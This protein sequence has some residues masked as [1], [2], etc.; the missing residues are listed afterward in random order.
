MLK[1]INLP[2]WF[3]RLIWP[4]VVI[5]ILGYFIAIPIYK[6]GLWNYLGIEKDI[7]PI[8][9]KIVNKYLYHHKRALSKEWFERI[10]RIEEKDLPSIDWV[11]D[12]VSSQGINSFYCLDQQSD[13]VRSLL[14][15]DWNLPYDKTLWWKAMQTG[16]YLFAPDK[17]PSP[18]YDMEKTDSTVHIKTGTKY[19]TWIYLVAK[20]RQPKVYA[21]EFDF[22]TH[23]K[24][25]ETLQICFASSS[26]ASRFRFNLENNETMKFDIVDHATFLYWARTDLWK[27]YRFPCSIPLHK[28]V[29]VR[30][31]CI[32]NKFALYY[33]NKL[34][35]AVEINDYQAIQ[36]YWYL[37]FWNGTP[38]EKF[39]GKQDNYMDIE[40]KNFKIYHQRNDK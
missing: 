10:E 15:K 36:N 17:S 29:H 16:E 40:L 23:T 5:G 3:K 37:I 21:L 39:K 28:P 9:G 12:S 8:V 14:M 34:I 30:L 7:N 20:Q 24:T 11:E 33:D 19:D 18:I 35:M 26:L 32:N 2:Q 13:D 31:E 38:N 22:I 1:R 6:V 4:L 25:Q 27:K